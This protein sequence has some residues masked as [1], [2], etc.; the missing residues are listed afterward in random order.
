ME[1]RKKGPKPVSIT[2][3]DAQVEALAQVLLDYVSQRKHL[4]LCG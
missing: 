1:Q 3:E 4:P 2:V